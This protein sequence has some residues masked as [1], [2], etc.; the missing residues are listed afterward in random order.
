MTM[1]LC[2]QAV[3]TE[4]VS[5]PGL[6][7]HTKHAGVILL[8]RHHGNMTSGPSATTVVPPTVSS[9]LSEYLPGGRSFSTA[10]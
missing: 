1:A 9:A 7:R 8:P 5:Q 4:V 10:R 6:T 3:D 2:R